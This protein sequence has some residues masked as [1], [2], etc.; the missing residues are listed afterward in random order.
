[1]NISLNHTREGKDYLFLSR[2]QVK[3]LSREQIKYREVL[4]MLRK[5]I[6]TVN[7]ALSLPSI[8]ITV[9]NHFFLSLNQFNRPLM[10]GAKY[11]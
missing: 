11:L 3:A 8:S 1:M 7:K 9:E 2:V 5:F 6:K 10:E 4:T